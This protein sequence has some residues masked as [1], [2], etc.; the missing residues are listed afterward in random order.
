MVVERTAWKRNRE[1]FYSF[2]S[3][4]HYLHYAISLSLFCIEIALVHEEIF[5]GISI[6]IMFTLF[7]VGL[8]F[9]SKFIY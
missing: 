1:N 2:Q 8:F 6:I 4:K 9:S 5:K 7:L 3:I